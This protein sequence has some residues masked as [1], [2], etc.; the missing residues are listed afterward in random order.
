MEGHP[1][2]YRDPSSGAI[3]NMNKKGAQ[4]ARDARK[5]REKQEETIKD[6]QEEVKDLKLL[7]TQLLERMDK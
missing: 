6:L 7:L 3:I 4:L 2:L 1:G 5:K